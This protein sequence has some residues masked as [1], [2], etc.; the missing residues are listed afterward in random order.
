M[1]RPR[2]RRERRVTARA[3]PRTGRISALVLVAAVGCSGGHREDPEADLVVVLPR[4]AEELDPR[5]VG[6]PYGLRLSRLIF[7]SLVRINPRTLEVE[8][9]LAASIA[10]EGPTR[11]R[12]LLHEGLRF[13]D[14]SVLDAEDVRSTFASLVDPALGSR[15][16]ATYRRIVRVEV[17][18]PRELIF[19]LTEPHATFL[20]DLEIPIM[21]AEDRSTH[22]GTRHNAFPIGAGPYRLVRREP[23]HLRIAPNPHWHRGSPRFEVVQFDVVRDDNTRALRMLA[24]EGDL[25][26]HAIPPLLLPLFEDDPR[27][28]VRSVPGINTFYLGVH[29]GSRVLSRRLVRQALAHAIDRRALVETELGGFGQV[30]KSWIPPGH[31][32]ERRSQGGYPHDVALAED[33][34]DR[35]GFVRGP[36]SA[37]R[38]RLLLRVGSDRF[39]VSVARAIAAMLRDVGVAV[40]VRPSETAAMVADLNRG[41]FDLC[42]LQLPELIEP[43]VLSWF[44]SS[45]RIPSGDGGAGANRWRFRNRAFD[46][47]LELGRTHTI[48]ATG[49]GP[50][51]KRS[52]F[53]RRSF[54]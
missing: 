22:V 10:I 20:T 38:A 37:P 39:R 12:V 28:E 44:F 14:G 31:W 21:R 16:A 19:H 15:Y 2:F 8:P 4:D 35:A 26:V 33:L 53:L 48:E 5:F 40:E 42:L 18:S 23:G 3:R 52:G 7:A 36:A 17:R 11:Y 47:A 6:D 27:F 24:G 34:L 43:H 45:D 30:A 9:D 13:S 41:R 1:S 50:T 25:A 49:R 54:P 51:A 32:A 46:R 29:T